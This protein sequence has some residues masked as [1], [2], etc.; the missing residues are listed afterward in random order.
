[1]TPPESFKADFYRIGLVLAIKAIEKIEGW[2]TPEAE[3]LTEKLLH[4]LWM[5]LEFGDTVD[6]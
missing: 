3:A 2:D 4:Q 5:C 6:A 1:M